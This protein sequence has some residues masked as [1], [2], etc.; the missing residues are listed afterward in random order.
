MI[1][2]ALERDPQL[3]MQLADLFAWTVDFYRIQKDDVFSVVYK[4]QIGGWRALR[5]PRD[6]RCAVHQWWDGA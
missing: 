5:N 6:R 1:W 2:P 3:A 4:E